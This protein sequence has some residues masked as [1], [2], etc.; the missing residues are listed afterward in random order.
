MFLPTNRN[1]RTRRHSQMDMRNNGWAGP[2]VALLIVALSTAIVG[3][4][5]D[6]PA[7][8]AQRPS[9]DTFQFDRGVW[10]DTEFADPTTP[11]GAKAL[12]RRRRQADALVT[13]KVLTGLRPQQARDLLGE[14]DRRNSSRGTWAFLVGPSRGFMVDTEYLEVRIRRDRVQAARLVTY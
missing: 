2:S 9:C 3:A 7:A 14:P 8:R 11:D 10:R 5:A 4:V 13:C 1:A 12:D 6:D